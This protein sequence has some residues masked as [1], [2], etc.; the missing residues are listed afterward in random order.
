MGK[1][2]LYLIES[3]WLYDV[4]SGLS[5]YACNSR[6]FCGLHFICKQRLVSTAL[7]LSAFDGLF[8][9]LTTDW[10]QFCVHARG[11]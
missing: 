8:S 11:I 7:I 10:K 9:I 6:E 1:S 3:D 5:S 4:S 2:Y